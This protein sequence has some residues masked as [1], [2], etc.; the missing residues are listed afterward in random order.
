MDQL[1]AQGTAGLVRMTPE[2][3]LRSV[4]DQ[5]AAASKSVIA[6]AAARER[7]EYVAL[8]TANRAGVRLL[9]ACLLGKLHRPH[10]DPR[11]PYTEIGGGSSFSGRSYDEQHLTKFINEHRAGELDHGVLDARAAEHR[12]PSH[13]GPRTRRQASRPLQENFGTA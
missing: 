1:R 12:R 8:C 6:D 7:I 13:D 5:A 10:V 9:M 2:E 3:I 11:N 4:R